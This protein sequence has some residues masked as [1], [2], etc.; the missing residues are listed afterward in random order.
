MLRFVSHR[1][2]NC[3]MIQGTTPERTMKMKA[4]PLTLLALS[5]LGCSMGVHRELTASEVMGFGE[6][7]TGVEAARA[8]WDDAMARIVKMGIEHYR[9]KTSRGSVTGAR[10]GGGDSYKA[11]VTLW[12]QAVDEARSDAEARTSAGPRAAVQETGAADGSR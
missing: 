7:D 9:V 5:L 4:A 12:V 8:A 11:M 1:P 2:G 3:V 6:G 10:I